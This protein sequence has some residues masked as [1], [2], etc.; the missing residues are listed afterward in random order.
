MSEKPDIFTEKSI[1]NLQS[2][3][4]ADVVVATTSSWMW[5]LLAGV[6][7]AVAA[8]VYWG[9]FGTMVDSVRG[10]GV[11]V[12]MGGVDAVV[13]KGQGIIE[14]LNVEPGSR[15][16][17]NQ[18]VGQ[19]YN[20]ENFFRMRKFEIEFEQLGRRN[21]EIKNGILQVTQAKIGASQQ[22]EHAIS[23]LLAK[24]DANTKRATELNEQF[25]KLSEIGGSSKIE[26]YKSLQDTVQTESQVTGMLLQTIEQEVSQ[27]D[28]EWTKQQTYLDLL[29]DQHLKEQEMDLALKLFNDS[30]WLRA[31]DEGVVIE[32]LKGV[33]S[34][35]APGDRV[36]LISS[37][38]GPDLRLVAFVP[39]QDG[40]K[41]RPGMS[42][43]FT[44][45]SVKAQDYGYIQG[46]V[47]SVSQFSVSRESISTEL[48]NTDF[49]EMVAKGGGQT[50][51]VVELMPGD[52]GPGS[53]KWTSRNGA[54]IE[55]DAGAS[56]ALLINTAYRAPASYIIPYLREKILGIGAAKP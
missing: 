24:L 17:A 32:V 2:S 36:A 46:V 8:V 54:G 53:F 43:F 25:R 47:M 44:P 42:A 15:V 38:K 40:K 3:R 30:Y 29:K 52:R 37:G 9:F 10:M 11:T 21:S 13:A 50:R 1:E 49:A 45:A 7:L 26:Y 39:M 27:K 41:I 19:I 55:V 12:Q 18:I 51:V 20:A 22:K 28:I 56:G 35:V 48:K 23:G 31:I 34:P 33:G 14:H 6:T 5:F 16:V 4:K